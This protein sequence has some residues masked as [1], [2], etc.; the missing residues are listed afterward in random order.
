M[1]ARLLPDHAEAY[2]ALRLRGLREHPEAFTSSYEEELDRPLAVALA[3]LTPS[4][5]LPNDVFFGAWRGRE[6]VGVLGLQGRY[7]MKERHT[8]TVVGTFVAPEVRGMAVGDALMRA[9]LDHAR[10]C[11]ELVQLD[12]TVTAGNHHAQ[13]LYERFGFGKWGVYPNAV[14]VNGLFVDKVHMVRKLR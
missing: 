3:R 5:A 9:L 8:A 10:N 6:L 11:S 12:L 4:S 13:C 14:C 2:Q 1:V 7:R